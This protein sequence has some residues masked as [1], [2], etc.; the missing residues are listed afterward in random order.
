MLSSRIIPRPTA[1]LLRFL[2]TTSTSSPAVLGG[3]PED[4]FKLIVE[5]GTPFSNEIMNYEFLSC[6]PGLGNCV[7]RLPFRKEFI[8][9]VALPAI[10]GGVLSSLIDH[11]A[12]FGAWSLLP[13]ISSRVSTSDLHI[14]YVSPAGAE[15]IIAAAKLVN[16]GKKIIV[17]D[18]TVY[19]EKTPDKIIAVGRGSFYRLNARENKPEDLV[20]F[21]NW[22]ESLKIKAKE[23]EEK[24]I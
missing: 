3:M 16:A 10:H 7:V 2:G 6:T 21:N 20:I 18:V 5:N 17:M 13:N 9:N 1:K 8:G 23:K 15:P 14:S 11:C 4:E 12:G 24:K 19:A 22:I